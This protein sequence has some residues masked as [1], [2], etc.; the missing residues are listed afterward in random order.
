MSAKKS[1]LQRQPDSISLT[2]ATVLLTVTG[3]SEILRRRRA[4]AI[5]K[6]PGMRTSEEQSHQDR[7][8]SPG[9][10]DYPAAHRRLQRRA[11]RRMP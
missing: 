6:Y 9:Q 10:G 4:I 7:V 11:S 2:C 1:P 3:A 5:V 8:L